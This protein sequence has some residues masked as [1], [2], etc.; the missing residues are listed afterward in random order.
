MDI[1]S[2]TDGN[3]DN[4]QQL[5]MAEIDATLEYDS[6][7]FYWEINTYQDAAAILEVLILQQQGL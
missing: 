5:V 4:I 6:G 7:K 3:L 2:T 1:V